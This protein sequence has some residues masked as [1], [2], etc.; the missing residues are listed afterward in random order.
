MNTTRQ[1]CRYVRTDRESVTHPL[2]AV[3]TNEYRDTDDDQHRGNQNPERYHQIQNYAER[4]KRNEPRKSVAPD[5]TAFHGS[6]IDRSTY[7]S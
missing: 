3:A 5:E 2:P 6:G 1:I 4:N 7:V